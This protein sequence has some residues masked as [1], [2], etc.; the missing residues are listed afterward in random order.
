MALVSHK[1]NVTTDTVKKRL[2]LRREGV[3]YLLAKLR[4]IKK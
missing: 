1:K 2:I 3:P 4:L